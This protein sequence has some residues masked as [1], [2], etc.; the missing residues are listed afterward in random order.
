MSITHQDG[1]TAQYGTVEAIE[2]LSPSMIRIVFGGDGLAGFT[3]TDATDQYV[4]AA[5]VPDGAPYSVPFDLDE[6][7]RL[8]AALRPRNRR[9]TIRAWDPESRQVTIDFVAHGETGHAG[10][11]AQ[12][13]VVGDRLQMSGPSGGY[14]PDPTAD[15]Y[16]MAGDESALPA[17][18]ASLSVLAAGRTCVVMAVVDGPDHEIELPNS[19]DVDVRWLHRCAASRPENLLV[20]AVAE[21]EW[22]AGRAD[23]FIHGEAAEVRA[24]RRHLIAERGVD[25]ALASI[26]PYWRRDHTDE[27]WRDIKRQWLAE[28]ER[29]V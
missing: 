15:W 12:R 17:I 27:A 25:R 18:A 22:P 2:R 9:Y 14:R 5:F 6:V 11:W 23:V 19:V 7:R 24:V 26:S 3:P 8:E 16:L 20:D 21:L 29:D 13:A 28:Q 1:T 10:R 4:N